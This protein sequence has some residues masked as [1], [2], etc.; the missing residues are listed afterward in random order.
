MI[1]TTCF[2][3]SVCEPCSKDLEGRCP[4]CRSPGEYKMVFRS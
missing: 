2:H 1:N 3:L 4:I